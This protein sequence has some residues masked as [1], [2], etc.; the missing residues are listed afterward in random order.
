MG[1]IMIVRKEHDEN[2]LYLPKIIILLQ[3]GGE[4]LVL[5][6]SS[7]SIQILVILSRFQ[8][9]GTKT[10]VEG[11]VWSHCSKKVPISHSQIAVR[12]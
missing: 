12:C 2:Y 6:C 5:F 7:D 1:F 10:K 11:F 8:T 3:F 9:F 4:V